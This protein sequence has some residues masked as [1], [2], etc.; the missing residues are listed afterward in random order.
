MGAEGEAG[1]GG[2]E[3]REGAGA[4]RGGA[5]QEPGRGRGWGTREALTLRC[6]PSAAE[7]AG[8]LFAGCGASCLI[9]LPA[10]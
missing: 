3:A 10:A 1:V 7:R 2:W 8:Y 4:G 9:T 5:E 6:L